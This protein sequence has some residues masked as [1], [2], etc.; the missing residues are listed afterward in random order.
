MRVADVGFGGGH[1]GDF[2]A[3]KQCDRNTKQ[4][5]SATRRL[6][7]AVRGQSLDARKS[8]KPEGGSG[9][10]QSRE[11]IDNRIHEAL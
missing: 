6:A 1:P 7:V 11:P 3:L 10:G 5:L 9:G 8:G 2:A 4:L